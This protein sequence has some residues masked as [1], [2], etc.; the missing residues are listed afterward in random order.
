MANSFQKPTLECYYELSRGVYR[1]EAPS[2]FFATASTPSL[3]RA[4]NKEY[5]RQLREKWQSIHAEVQE[6]SRSLNKA[7]GIFNE[8]TLRHCRTNV[9]QDVEGYKGLIARPYESVNRAMPGSSHLSVFF[10][11]TFRR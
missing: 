5:W 8:Q 11:H 1:G 4:D 3:S 10:T 6:Q 2:Y 7:F 9:A